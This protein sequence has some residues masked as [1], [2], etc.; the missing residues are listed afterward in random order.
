VTTFDVEALLAEISPDAPCGEDISYDAD[1]MEL[2]RLAEGTAETQ[3]GDYIQEGEGAD[4]KKVFQLSIKL[5]E[6]SRDLRVILYL[7]A[8][9][10][11]LKGLPGFCDGLALLQGIVEHYWEHLFPQLDPDD[12]NDPLER[13]N[14]LSSLSPSASMMSDQDSMKIIPGLMAVP[15]CLPEDAR[16]PQ[17]NLRHMLIATGELSIPEAEA[18]G[19]PTI[20]LIDAAFEQA[21]IDGL[22]ATDRLLRTCLAHLSTLDEQLT[23]RVGAGVAPNFSR[24]EQL[25]Q[26]MQSKTEMYM[27]RR[28]YRPDESSPSQSET[29]SD[30]QKTGLDESPAPSAG[31]LG[32]VLSGQIS[33]D[34]DV[35]KALDMVINYYENNEPSSPVPLVIKRAK[36]LVGRSFVDIIRDLSPDAM[37]QV[38]LVS[39]EEDLSG[40]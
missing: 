1:F 38:Q 33:S 3:V 40:E 31:I 13:M 18:K 2:E 14:I 15:L 27:Q 29:A 35:L 16:L 32:Q 4:W 21:D 39:G 24:L 11:R 10:L 17:P 7:T 12:D 22:Q 8:S 36:R 37:S 26:Q 28:G 9:A 23:D 34:Q 6:R 30:V 19:L 5:L 25:L 20:Q